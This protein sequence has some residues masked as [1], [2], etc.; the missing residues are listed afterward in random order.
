M[1]PA[2]WEE[3][4]K[5]SREGLLDME[6]RRARLAEREAAEMSDDQAGVQEALRVAA[7]FSGYDGSH[8]KQWVIDQ[9]VRALTG[10]QYDKWVE[11]FNLGDEGP[12]TYLWEEGIAP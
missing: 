3:A 11:K 7:E 10:D 9:M 1:I 2:S 5:V 4:L 6:A 8:H 12:D